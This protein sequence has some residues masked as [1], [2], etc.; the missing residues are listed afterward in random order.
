MAPVFISKEIIQGGDVEKF[1]TEE[2]ETHLHKSLVKPTGKLASSRS[3]FHGFRFIEDY[4]IHRTF[5]IAQRMNVL[6]FT[7]NPEHC[8]GKL[9]ARQ[10]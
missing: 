2:K 4:I 5:K 9:S 6:G 7:L 3:I 1:S 10:V 8:E